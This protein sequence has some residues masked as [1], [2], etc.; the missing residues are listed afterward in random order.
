MRDRIAVVVAHPDDEVLWF[1]GFIIRASHHTPVDIYC[2]SQSARHPYTEHFGKAC[3]TLGATSSHISPW[4]NPIEADIALPLDWIAQQPLK[5][6]SL[7]V[8]HGADGEYGHPQHIALHKYVQSLRLPAVYRSPNTGWDVT[9]S[10]GELLIKYHALKKYD[11][12]YPAHTISGKTCPKWKMVLH[13]YFGGDPKNMR[14]EY[15]V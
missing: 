12:L 3:L 5:G 6:Y 7:I 1:G 13:T 15:Y 4:V 2:C 9:L 10:D 14:T 11:M 8:A